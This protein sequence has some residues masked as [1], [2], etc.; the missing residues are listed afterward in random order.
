MAAGDLTSTA[1]VKKWIPGITGATDDLLLD[2]LVTAASAWI[3]NYTNRDLL[4][5]SY[6]ETLNGTGRGSLI[7]THYPVTAV[8]SLSV[9]GAAVVARPSVTTSGFTFEDRV[10]RLSGSVF[11]KGIQNI[12]VAYTA[13]FAT[14]PADLEQCAIELVG[15]KYRE[16]TRIG[17]STKAMGDQTVSF[18]VRELPVQVKST[19]D[20]YK[21]VLYAA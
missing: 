20:Q 18:L 3:K 2:M 13:G 5:A 16:R 14:A 6:T 15:L 12:V 1:N 9:D 21:R 11:T 7:L 4:T 10:I 19:L 8:A 17:E